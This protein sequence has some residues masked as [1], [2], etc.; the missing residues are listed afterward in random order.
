ML[1]FFTR[2]IQLRRTTPALAVPEKKN[3]EVFGYEEQ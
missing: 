1:R 2:L 3:L